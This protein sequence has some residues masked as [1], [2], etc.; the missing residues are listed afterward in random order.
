MSSRQFAALIGF[1]FAVVWIAE[2]LGDALLCLLAAAIGYAAVAFYEGDIDLAE[3]QDRVR[4]EV[5][6]ART[7][8]APRAPARARVR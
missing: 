3:V 7:P 1:V 6:P 8:G 5:P 4:G 2:S